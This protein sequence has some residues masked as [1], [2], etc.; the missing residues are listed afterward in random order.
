RERISEFF[1]TSVEAAVELTTVPRILLI[2]HDF[3]LE[4]TTTVLWLV[5]RGIDIRCL[6]LQPYKLGDRV[7][8]DV[9]Q[10]LPLEE[11][12]EYQVRIRQK[13]ENVRRS[14]SGKQRERTLSVLARHRMVHEGTE[15]EIIP[16]A[17]PLDAPQRDKRI[18]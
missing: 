9:R 6:Q 17:L 16:K 4:I 14:A 3:S 12:S 10:V 11:A 5:E 7:L 2:A 15:I 8:I 13:D 1:G 18:F